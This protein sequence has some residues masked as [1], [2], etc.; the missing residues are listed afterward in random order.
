MNVNTLENVFSKPRLQSYLASQKANPQKAVALYRQNIALARSFYPILSSLE[1][2]LRNSIDKQCSAHFADPDWLTNQ[3]TGFMV[4]PRLTYTLRGRQRT[5]NFLKKSVEDA[6]SKLIRQGRPVT[7]GRIISELTFAFWTELFAKTHY[8]LLKGVPI[9][10]FANL[11]STVKR[12]Q[13][14]RTLTDIRQ[15]RNR[16]YH[17]EPICFLNGACD[18]NPAALVRDQIV[19]LLGW[20]SPILPEWVSE[21]DDSDLELI[22]T[23]KFRVGAGSA[24]RRYRAFNAKLSKLVRSFIR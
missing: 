4:D 24:G 8:S 7:Q 15:F 9:R 3:K 18:L 21:I 5:N 19:E 6:E 13:V 10:A 16:I 14:Y 22:M 23:E 11:P 2:A 20:L 17:N 12:H 1:V